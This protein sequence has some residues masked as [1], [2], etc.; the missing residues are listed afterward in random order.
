MYDHYP[1]QVRRQLQE[2]RRRADMAEDALTRVLRLAATL[3]AHLERQITAAIDGPT[4]QKPADSCA[5]RPGF[6]RPCRTIHA[7]THRADAQPTTSN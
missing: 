5:G 2:A 6:C 4:A 3:P 1:A 7:A